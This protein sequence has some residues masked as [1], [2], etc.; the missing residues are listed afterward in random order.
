MS[1]IFVCPFCNQKLE[2]EDEQENQMATCP[3]CGGEIV[4]QKTSSKEQD[5]PDDKCV[6]NEIYSISVERK[7][8]IHKKTAVL[9]LNLSNGLIDITGDDRDNYIYKKTNAFMEGFK[10]G[11]GQY[12]YVSPQSEITKFSVCR[13]INSLDLKYCALSFFRNNEQ[14]S[15]D[16]FFDAVFSY[17]LHN[18]SF[19]E[20]VGGK[21]EKACDCCRLFCDHITISHSGLLN[22][23]ST[24][25]IQGEK[26]VYFDKIIAI[27]VKEPGMLSGYM[28]FSILGEIGRKDGVVGAM[29]DENSIVLSSPFEFMIAKYIRDYINTSC[30]N[31]KAASNGDTN[32]FAAEIIKLKKLLDDGIITKNDFDAFVKKMSR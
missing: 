30:K 29:G 18:N 24:M 2:C 9:I 27:Q 10:R 22:A 3:S 11:Q 32:D 25:G 15:A 1:F 5:A 17:K 7:G 13:F 20:L 6:N 16:V 28:Q 26:T 23:I 14:I 8:F 21:I 12:Y 31:P 19:V 4:P